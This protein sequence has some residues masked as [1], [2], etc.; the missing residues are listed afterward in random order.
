MNRIILTGN[1]TKDPEI[2]TVGNSGE[3][4]AAFDVAV[5]RPFK[6]KQTGDYE[7]DFFHCTAWRGS[8]TY[9]GKY[10]HKGDRV[11]LEGRVQNRSWKDKDGQTKYGT[12]IVVNALEG[13]PKT[14]SQDAPEHTPPAPEGFQPVQDPEL[15]F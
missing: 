11:A 9:A 14:R 7:T 8:A 5:K 13:T 1:L 3:T 12:E 6:S 2:K 4:C 10:L 15:P